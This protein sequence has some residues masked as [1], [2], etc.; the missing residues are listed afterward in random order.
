MKYFVYLAFLSFTVSCY[1]KAYPDEKFA[2][3]SDYRNL[4]APYKMGDTLVFKS[5]RGNLDSFLISSIDSAM[6]NTKGGF[7]SPR[8]GKF[9]MVRY[10]QIPIDYW[11]TS[12]IEMGANNKNP[13]EVHEDG[14]LLYILKHPDDSSTLVDFGFKNWGY[15]SND[16]IGPLLKDMVLSDTVR[17]SN[18][19]QIKYCP[20]KT[21]NDNS[22]ETVYSSVRNG[23]V[24]Y[25][26]CDGEQ[27]LRVR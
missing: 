4:V 1:S 23:I 26:A 5:N 8:P 11:S 7:M 13:K 24:A 6:T 18:G 21:I 2:I 27:W 20:E 17:L 15:C 14:S 12:R 9:I 3:D 25:I 19:Y 10:R 16:Q 22:I